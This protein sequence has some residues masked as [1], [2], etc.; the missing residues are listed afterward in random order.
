ML[1]AFYDFDGTLVS[2][3]V[4]TRYFYFARRAP[5]A[6]D[7]LKRSATVVLGIPYWVALDKRS[8]LAFNLRF[9]QEYKGLSRDW[10]DKAAEDIFERE[11]RPK[12]YAGSAALLDA[13]RQAGYTPVLV[14]G[15]LDFA[16]QPAIEHFGFDHVLAN[17]MVFESGVATGKL[18][19]PV[20]AEA[21]KVKAMEEFCQSYNVDST[22]ARGYS[23]S[24]SDLPMLEAVGQPR[25]VNPDSRLRR[26]AAQRGWPVIETKGRPNG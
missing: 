20:L 3:N 17:K 15:G 13:D 21:G 5:G 18:I 10:L 12:I 1:A 11:I 4:V 25:A 9:Y 19:E 22:Q 8:R 23:D 26:A 14:T 24:F 2:S 7:S 16:I 6:L